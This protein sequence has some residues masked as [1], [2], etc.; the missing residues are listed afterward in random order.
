MQSVRAER[1]LRTCVPQRPRISSYG[2][3]AQSL[4]LMSLV[5]TTK[6]SSRSLAPAIASFSDPEGLLPCSALVLAGVR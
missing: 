1:Q 4:G 2:G 6:Q 5:R 3:A